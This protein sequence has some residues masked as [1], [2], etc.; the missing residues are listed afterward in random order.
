[1]TDVK[2][3]ALVGGHLHFFLGMS[4]ITIVEMIEL[5]IVVIIRSLSSTVHETAQE[6]SNQ[7]ESSASTR[8]GSGKSQRASIALEQVK[9]HVNDQ[10]IE[11]RDV[12]QSHTNANGLAIIA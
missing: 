2:F 5:F 10:V 4:L 1:M 9:G 3:L 12:G 8:Q 7:R 6:D 11:E